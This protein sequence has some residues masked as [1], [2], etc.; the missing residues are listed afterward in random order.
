MGNTMSKQMIESRRNPK[1]SGII[2]TQKL[3]RQA[4]PLNQNKQ[5]LSHILVHFITRKIYETPMVNLKVLSNVLESHNTT[6]NS[7][8][9]TL[10]TGKGGME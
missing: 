5:H 6:E 9:K 3:L 2:N 7:W 4:T 1:L 10:L 8:H